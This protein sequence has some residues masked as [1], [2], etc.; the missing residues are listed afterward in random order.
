MPERCDLYCFRLMIMLVKLFTTH[1]NYV[2]IINIPR[3]KASRR[4]VCTSDMKF[5][6]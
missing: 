2:F 5:V 4:E 3:T 6:F 1:Y